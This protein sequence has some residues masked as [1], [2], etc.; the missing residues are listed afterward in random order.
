MTAPRRVARYIRVSRSD[1]NP[2]LQLDETARV[3]AARGWDL[4]DTCTDHGISGSRDHR[5]ELDRMLKDAKQGR[6]NTLLVWRSDRLFR[7]LRHMVVTIEELAARGVDFVSVTA[8]V[9]TTT[10]QGRLL[11][12][13]VSAFAEFER[14][15]LIER[16][17][18]GLDAARRRGKRIGRPPVFVDVC[19]ALRL[20][21]RGLT[22]REIA[23]RMHVGYG[24]LHRALRA[25]QASDSTARDDAGPPPP[26]A[27]Q[28]V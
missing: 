15:V 24:T 1:Q 8:P 6:F 28:P 10:P 13:L 7:S 19:G 12:H 21:K 18:A 11:L 9:D 14:Q 17:K 5:P 27:E 16:T 20:R 22:V 25:A 26:G 4:V 23:A 2:S 3:I